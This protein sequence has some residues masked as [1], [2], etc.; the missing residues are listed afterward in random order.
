MCP[1]IEKI[2]KKI[3]DREATIEIG[4]D[5]HFSNGD[6]DRDRD[7]NFGDRAHTLHITH[8]GR[9]Q[10]TKEDDPDGCD[11]ISELLLTFY[12]RL[13]HFWLTHEFKR[14]RDFIMNFN[15][16]ILIQ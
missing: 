10:R 8:P 9:M 7:H 14:L 2:G 5:D 11:I 1:I 13:L 12:I 16:A 6:R 4:I 3:G 15:P